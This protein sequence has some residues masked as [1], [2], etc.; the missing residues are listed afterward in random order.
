MQV[1]LRDRWIALP[2]SANCAK[3][4]LRDPSV[5]ARLIDWCGSDR[6]IVHAEQSMDS[7]NRSTARNRATLGCVNLCV[8]TVL[9][10]LGHVNLCKLTF[11][12]CWD[13]LVKEWF[14]KHFKMPNHLD[15]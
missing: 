13:Q 4:L 9:A 7:A 1:L 2:L 3:C 15:L 14:E 5:V 6:S 10:I 8:L 11:E 12:P